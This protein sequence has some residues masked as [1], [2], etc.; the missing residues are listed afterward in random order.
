MRVFVTVVLFTATIHCT[1]VLQ[2]T[3]Y[4]CMVNVM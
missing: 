1:Y 3:V 2:P 4:Q